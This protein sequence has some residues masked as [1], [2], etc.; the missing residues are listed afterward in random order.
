[1]AAT[2]VVPSRQIEDLLSLLDEMFF[3]PAWHGPS[4]RGA[5]RRVTPAQ[6]VWR[7]QPG[8]HNIAELALHA[9][10]WKYAVRRRLTGGKRGSFALEGSN[11]FARD[12]VTGASCRADLA[13]LH[14]EHQRLCDAVRQVEAARLLQRVPG[15][16]WT[17]QQTIRGVAAHDA[18][19]AGQIQLLKR[20]APG[21]LKKGPRSS[22]GPWT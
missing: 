18:Y 21:G 20:L 7:A 14:D 6:A 17:V 10:Y 9:A 2:S 12:A 22:R 13:L 8:R 15:G 3:G 1:M 11:W 5:L 16:K 19:H 4:L